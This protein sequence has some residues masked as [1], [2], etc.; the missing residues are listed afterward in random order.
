MDSRFFERKCFV[1]TSESSLKFMQE[2][3]DDSSLTFDMEKYTKEIFLY[4]P[5]YDVEYNEDDII[6]RV[7]NELNV[8]INNIFVDGDKYCAAIYFTVKN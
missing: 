1:T 4:S 8:E 3:E 5:A 2:Q 7:S 6:E